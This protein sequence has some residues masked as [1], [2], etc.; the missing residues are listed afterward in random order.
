MV[1]RRF[2][3]LS[4]SLLLVC[5]FFGCASLPNFQKVVSGKQSLLD[6]PPR[7]RDPFGHLRP[8]EIQA[9]FKRIDGEIKEAD[10]LKKNVKLVEL[11]SGT[12]L[13]SDNR[14]T[15]LVD[16]SAT[17]CA[18]EKAIEKATD[19]INLETFKFMD[20]RVGRRFAHLLLKKLREGVSVNIIYDSAG[21]FRG[22]PEIF[23]RLRNAGARIVAFNPLDPLK[24]RGQWRP[25]Q[26]DHRKIL[27]VDGRVAFTGSI[28]ITAPG[29]LRIPEIKGKKYELIP[30]RETNVEI[31]GPAVA[32]FQ[33]LFLETWRQQNGP[34]LAK[35]AYFPSNP[36]AGADLVQVIGSAP[37]CS[38][39]VT[40]LMYLSALRFS[41]RS[42]FLTDSYFSP[43][44]Q[45]IRALCRA[46][47][48]GVDVRIL[49]PRATDHKVVLDAG[50]FYYA[51]LLRSGVKLY[52]RR[53][54]FLHAKSAVIDGVWS[55]IGSTNLDMWSLLR[56]NEI[57]AVI[58][59]QGFAKGMESLFASDLAES[60]PI[61]LEEWEKRPF[62]SRMQ[63]WFAHILG[64]W[65]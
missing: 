27:V 14:V 63:E 29:S 44:E 42:V 39:R 9:L 22:C 47:R 52:E 4:I 1:I 21:S 50:R 26:R 43:D 38:N 54:A 24:A 61:S 31:E 35:R 45:V 57:N 12:V 53:N 17:F 8:H 11:I 51:R 23:E 41:A 36:K 19:H 25:M 33:R 28:N 10:L 56:N 34:A 40:F 5:G 58:L 6:Q 64:P 7:I 49:L 18:M 20:D 16:S 3:S 55:T 62:S 30:W 13:S 2:A 59:N 65:L 15:L 32:D 37:G 46:A 60:A 48:R